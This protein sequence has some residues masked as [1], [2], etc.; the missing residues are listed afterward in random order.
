MLFKYLP[1]ARIDVLEGLSIRLTQPSALNDPFESA[2][3]V[4]AS[5]HHDMQSVVSDLRKLAEDEG[6]IP[7]NQEEEK[8]LE[9]ALAELEAHAN[10]L[11]HPSSIGKQL[12]E[13]LD[14]AQGVL[15]LSRTPDSL[16]MW[17]HYADSHKGLVLGLDESH[18][19]FSMPDGNG[20]PTRPHNVVYTSRRQTVQ[21]ASEDFYERLLCYKSLE[22]AY[23]QEVRIFRTFGRNQSDFAKNTK[24]S[25]YLFDI[26]TDCIKEIYLGANTGDDLAKRIIR[27]A[28]WHNLNV[29][30]FRGGISN[31]RYAVT[32]DEIAS[33]RRSYRDGRYEVS[34]TTGS[35]GYRSPLTQALPVIQRAHVSSTVDAGG[36]L[37]GFVACRPSYLPSPENS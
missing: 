17:S 21:V 3:L 20:R 12:I 13:H 27:A 36:A 7:T 23:E 25:I 8:I 11:M 34:L 31:D 22:W 2:I 37:Q 14:L 9:Q 30:I 29:N 24:I 15:S 35:S 16:L 6:L 28:E 26:P 18:E 10:D 4:D 32:F 5:G 1:P 33:I 19:F